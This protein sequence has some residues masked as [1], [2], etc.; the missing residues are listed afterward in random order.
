MSPA[1]T[2]TSGSVYSQPQKSTRSAQLKCWCRKL[3]A[4]G[5]SKDEILE[6]I[7]R[8]FST[9][10]GITDLQASLET[11]EEERR[12]QEAQP[13]RGNIRV[14]RQGVARSPRPSCAPSERDLFGHPIVVPSNPLHPAHLSASKPKKPMPPSPPLPNHD[15]CERSSKAPKLSTPKPNASLPS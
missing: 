3:L 7:N 6:A 13:Y 2:L 10:L 8:R 12:Q 1:P 9:T 11:I 14:T 5:L 4:I 15:Q